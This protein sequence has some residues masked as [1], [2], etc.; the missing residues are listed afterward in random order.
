MKHYNIH[1]LVR[2]DWRTGP[3]AIWL[4]PFAQW[5]QAKGYA[6]TTV[7]KKIRLASCFSLWLQQEAIALGNLSSSHLDRYLQ[8]RWQR[9]RPAGGEQR[10]LRQLTEFLQQQ[11][12]FSF[13]ECSASP[14]T[15]IELCVQAYERHLRQLRGLTTATVEN[16]LPFVRRFL[17]HRFGSGK[18]T[19][20]HLC[21]ADVVGFVQHDTPDMHPKRA[22]LLSTAL[23]SFL[24]YACNLGEV[25]LEL[26]AAVPSVANWSQLNI[27][28]GISVD[29]AEKLLTS[30]D[31]ADATGRRNY[32]MIILL[33]RLGVRLREIQALELDDIDWVNATLQLQS[34]SGRDRTL[35][36]SKE[37]GEAL[38]DYLS[39]GRP[40][41][42]T[43]RVFV[44]ARAPIEECLTLG[45]LYSVV[46][47]AIKRAGVSAPT[48]GAH[49]FRHGLATEMLRQQSS[50][51]EIGD[52]L[53]H[54]HPDTTRIYA[55]VDLDALR[56]LAL[57][58]PGGVQ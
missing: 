36:L 26:V 24:R 14:I 23:R 44:P 39:D 40:Q 50:L 4:D 10:T 17:Q 16:Y 46:R 13:E 21:A 33:V 55:K 12:G 48:F 31:R 49:Q 5:L 20:S 19:L 51:A 29:A 47:R 7:S 1:Q 3:L 43:R 6:S 9:L 22:K 28:R 25:N 35:P 30:I 34:R 58:W 45:G 15:D 2:S 54:V 52:L 27:P 8:Y 57:P 53:G 18:V 38:A 56:T 11:G 41:C 37:V 32:A 42:T